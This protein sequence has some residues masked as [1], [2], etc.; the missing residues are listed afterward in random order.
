MGIRDPPSLQQPSLWL[1]GPYWE[2]AMAVLHITHLQRFGRH[3]PN[4]HQLSR[5]VNV[6][7]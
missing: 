4:L 6:K 7:E 2:G 5:W 1:E 3:Q